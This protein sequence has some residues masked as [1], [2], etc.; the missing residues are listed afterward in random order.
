[1]KIHKEGHKI[2]R[3]QI[4]IIVLLGT[5]LLIFNLI[6]ILYILLPLITILLFSLFFFRIPQKNTIV[7]DGNI[8]APC[9]GKIVNIK[10][11]N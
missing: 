5:T 2:L 10:E 8:Y 4:I 7:K 3:N 9:D 1:M 6:Y 11:V